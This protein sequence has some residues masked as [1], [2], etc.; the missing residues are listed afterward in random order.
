MTRKTKG[1][2]SGK[3]RTVLKKA[4][5][6]RGKVQISRY[7]Q[8]FKEGD[9]V[10]ITIEPS[11]QKGMP[12]LRYKGY[13]GTVVCKQGRCYK[14]ALKSGNKD[15]QVISAPEHLTAAV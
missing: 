2:Q 15:M 5:R 3:S 14:I 8:N 11:S 10:I 13:R 9:E 6:E 4:A 7:I 12:R 1:M